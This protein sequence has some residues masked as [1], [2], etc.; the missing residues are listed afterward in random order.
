MIP[1]SM[2]SQGGEITRG[3]SP[4]DP[5]SRDP[6]DR[7]RITAPPN[8]YRKASGRIEGQFQFIS[9]KQAAGS[10]MN[11]DFLGNSPV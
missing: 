7:R 5:P 2:T 11:A 10:P 4:V 3:Q 1:I 6:L 9:L 8:H